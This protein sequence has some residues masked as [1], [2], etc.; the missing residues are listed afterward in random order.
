MDSYIHG[1]LSVWR[2]IA[3]SVGSI[4]VQMSL[5]SNPLADRVDMDESIHDKL[6]E[7]APM[8]VDVKD[9]SSLSNSND[10]E[11][12]FDA[13][14]IEKEEDVAVQVRPIHF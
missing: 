14:V 11:E 12:D 4:L 7:K 2:V 13:K 8:D 10:E 9:V 6:D 3:A 1:V 5:V